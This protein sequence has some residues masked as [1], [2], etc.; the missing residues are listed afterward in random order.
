MRY[1]IKEARGTNDER[2]PWKVSTTAY[3]YAVH[4]GHQRE[5]LAYH[6]HPNVGPKYPH[7]HLSKASNIT[8]VLSKK[9]IPTRRIALEE[10]LRFLIEELGVKPLRDNW[11]QT[12]ESTFKAHE[13]YRSWA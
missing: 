8:T 1:Q 12:L 10:M 11:S 13:R 5:I 4:N 7:L 2:G 3:Y 9:H 6:W